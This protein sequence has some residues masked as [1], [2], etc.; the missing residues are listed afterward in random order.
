MPKAPKP[1][2]LLGLA[3]TP[4]QTVFQ[5]EKK[6]EA[7]N[8]IRGFL[9]ELG[10]ASWDYNR[11]LVPMDGADGK[12]RVKFKA[13]LYDDKYFAMS[14]G[15]YQVSIFFGKRKAIVSVRTIEDLQAVL[16]AALMKYA[17]SESNT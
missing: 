4:N 9:H 10:F 13:A 14:K 5:L 7:L 16:K 11:I 17:V 12:P 8:A 1:A 15:Q 6:K 2:K 3:Q